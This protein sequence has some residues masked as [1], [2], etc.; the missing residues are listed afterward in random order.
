MTDIHTHILPGMDDG[1]AAVEESL[2]MLMAEKQQGVDVV[3][4]TPHF[5]RDRE[6]PRHF[7]KRREEASCALKRA[8]ELLPE[9]KQAALPKTYLGA[10]VRWRDD[11]H[12]WIELPQLCLGETRNVLVELPFYPWNSQMLNRLYELEE[13]TGVTPVIAHLERY[14]KSQR[15]EH[16][17]AIFSLGVP[18]QL[19]ADVLLRIFGRGKAI[20]L[21]RK[22]QAHLIASDCHNCSSRCPN[23]GKAISV[24]RNKLGAE[25]S[26]EIVR[27]AD[28]LAGI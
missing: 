8:I 25:Y 6:T 5:Y 11:M 17:R 14:L 26:D 4:L 12:E 27:C 19:S 21:L 2:D 18:V 10:E 13:R 9:A 20:E 23:L 1:A 7:L 16:I 15:A 24:V 3:V 28:V 22:G